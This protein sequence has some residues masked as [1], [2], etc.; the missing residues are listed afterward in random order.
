MRRSDIVG[1]I[2]IGLTACSSPSSYLQHIDNTLSLTL[3]PVDL[4]SLY[5]GSTVVLQVN[6]ESRDVTSEQVDSLARTLSIRDPE[7]RPVA[8]EKGTVRMP[9]PLASEPAELRIGLQLS[10]PKEGWYVAQL[11]VSPDK[12][13][14]STEERLISLDGRSFVANRFSVFARPVIRRLTVCDDGKV[15]IEFS[16]PVAFAAGASLPEVLVSGELLPCDGSLDGRGR[17]LWMTCPGIGQEFRLR[18]EPATLRGV[19]DG[20]PVLDVDQSAFDRVVSTAAL[21]SDGHCAYFVP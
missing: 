5:G 12:V 15:R 3:A 19:A 21:R 8:F 16:E 9:E 18:V 17:S 6:T 4:L 7:G 14:T 10:D 1:T 11:E 13:N 2:F 20:H